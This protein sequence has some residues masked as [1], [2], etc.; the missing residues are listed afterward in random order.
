MARHWTIQEENVKRKELYSL[1][2]VQNKT[3]DEIGSIVGIA[4]STVFDRLVRLRIPS[5]R[6]SSKEES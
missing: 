3:I 1:Y 2:S 6:L 5:P 4:E